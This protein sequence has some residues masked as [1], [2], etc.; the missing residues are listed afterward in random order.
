MSEE[1]SLY[2]KISDFRRALRARDWTPDKFLTLKDNKGFPYV[3]A[4]KVKINVNAVLPDS[5]LELVLT[6]SEL[7]MRPAIGSMSQH[8]TVRC[9]A[10]FVDI[11]T[12]ETVT[13]TAYGEAG[14][15]GDKGVGKCQTHAVKQIFFQEFLVA[16][17]GDPSEDTETTV[18][19]P[20]SSTFRPPSEDTK[21]VQKEQVMANSVLTEVPKGDGGPTAVQRR[22]LER[23]TKKLQADVESGAITPEQAEEIGSKLNAIK[24]SAEAKAFIEAHSR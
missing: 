5:E 21:K 4:E 10:T 19:T 20:A 23:I 15:S 18:A 3:S 13:Y 1:R 17:D 11:D 9:D 14:D 2:R 22:A 16:D 7:E 8:W 6:Y 24:T 12:Y